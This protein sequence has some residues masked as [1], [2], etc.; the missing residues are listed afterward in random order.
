MSKDIT[1][2]E[3]HGLV[4]ER[5]CTLRF[6]WMIGLAAAVAL[7]AATYMGGLS[8][9]SMRN[10]TSLS[11]IEKRLERIERNQDTMLRFMGIRRDG[12]ARNF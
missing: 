5:A 12:T 10:Q 2:V 9:R 11:S 1:A 8:D 7:G 3:S 4:T 6:R